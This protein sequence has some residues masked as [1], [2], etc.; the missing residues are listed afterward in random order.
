V[1]K[2]ERHFHYRHHGVDEDIE[3]YCVG[4]SRYWI[5]VT[6]V[7][8]GKSIL[9]QAYNGENARRRAISHARTRLAEAVVIEM[10][11]SALRIAL[12]HAIEAIEEAESR[13]T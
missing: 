11:E 1:S 8:D 5:E 6:Q 9:K 3:V 13:Q 10:V 2:R 12:I 4:G 7:S